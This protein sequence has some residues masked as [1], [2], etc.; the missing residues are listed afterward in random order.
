MKQP[1]NTVAMSRR[2]RAGSVNVFDSAVISPAGSKPMWN[3]VEF[4]WPFGEANR[5]ADPAAVD[6]GRRLA[7]SD[8]RA[9][10]S[11]TSSFVPALPASCYSEHASHLSRRPGDG[12]RCQRPDPGPS[13][14][15]FAPRCRGVHG[16][17]ERAGKGEVGRP[18]LL[19]AG[20]YRYPTAQ[21]GSF[22][23][24]C[25]GDATATVVGESRTVPVS[26]GAWF[27]RS[28]TTPSTSTASTAALPAGWE[29][30]R[31]RL[32]ARRIQGSR[33]RPHRHP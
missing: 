31:G 33:R 16:E 15:L 22:T 4:G 23:I 2:T 20:R 12:D 13:G 29:P 1:Q 32:P 8:R 7:L 3:F 17:R 11:I 9:M 14:V 26:A 10:G 25:V 27:D 30:R 28:R 21:T 24:S 18:E 6:P 19:C 5:E